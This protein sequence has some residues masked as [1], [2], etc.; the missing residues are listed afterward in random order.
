M[1][2]VKDILEEFET[3]AFQDDS[4]ILRPHVL[5]VQNGL[6]I[7]DGLGLARRLPGAV[8]YRSPGSAHLDRTDGPYTAHAGP[9]P[10][11]P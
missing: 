8:E 2:K 4:S 10:P 11:P 9:Q 7:R 5:A 6:N 3:I 1:P